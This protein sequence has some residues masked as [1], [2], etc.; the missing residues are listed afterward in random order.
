MPSVWVAITQG[1]GEFVA[2]FATPEAA[3][4]YYAVEFKENPYTGMLHAITGAGN[5]CSFAYRAMTRVEAADFL[6]EGVPVDEVQAPETG[7]HIMLWNPLLED[8]THLLLRCTELLSQ[9]S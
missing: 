8:H 6:G 7:Y 9:D 4:Q 2:A 1:E 5:E 3:F